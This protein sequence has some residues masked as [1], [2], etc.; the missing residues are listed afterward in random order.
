MAGLT[1]LGLV[2]HRRHLFVTAPSPSVKPGWPFVWD[3]ARE[4]YFRPDGDRLTLCVC[5]EEPHPP[6]SPEVSGEVRAAVPALVAE[7]FPA[8]AGVAI[9]DERACLRTFAPDRRYAIG[10]DPRL[11][12]FFWVAGLGGS[13]AVAGA[14]IG[15]MAADLLLGG[16]GGAEHPADARDFDPCRLIGTE[17]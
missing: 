4:V 9:E 17:A 11:P 2:P 3:L 6:G 8:L 1:D 7:A 15:E 12:G 10:P 13:G 14:A 16:D 5:D